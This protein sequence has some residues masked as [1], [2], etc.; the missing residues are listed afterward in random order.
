MR[1]LQL[2]FISNQTTIRWFKLINIVERNRVFTIGE[3]ADEL[4]VSQRTVANDIRHLKEHFKGSATFFSGSNGFI[5]E[6]VNFSLYKEQKKELL[7]NE[8]LF[9]LIKNIFYGRLDRVDELAHFYNYSETTF[10][11]ILAKCNPLL[12]SYGLKWVSNPL[13]IGGTE[14]CLRK[15]FKDF[16]Y[17]GI[18]TPYSV[19]PEKKLRDLVLKT[20]GEQLSFDSYEIASGT[21]PTAFYYTFYIAIRRSNQGLNVRIPQKILERVYKEKDFL[22]LFSLKE[23]IKDIFGVQLPK[24]EFAWIYLITVCNRTFNYERFEKNFYTQFNLWP[25]I[26]KITGDFLIHLK[27]KEEER[28]KLTVFLKSFFL[29]IKIKDSIEPV[30]NKA[31][32]DIL[33]VVSSHDEKHY[34]QN[35]TF[36]QRYKKQFPLSEKYI[37]DVC[38]SLT[39]YSSLLIHYYAPS[40]KIFFLL[41]GNHLAY[42]YTRIKALQLFGEKHTLIFVPIQI[43]SQEKLMNADMDLIVTNYSRYLSEFTNDTDYLLIK[44]IPDERDWLNIATK[45]NEYII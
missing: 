23:G 17:E 34:A 2:N 1:E 6:E 18:E 12:K 31:M 29:S 16:F 24:V 5:F 35:L 44:D 26:D 33:N 43:L 7:K 21:T 11:R 14:A 13:R 37:Q 3:L 39:I 20:V 30:L 25:E 10:R 42:Q 8:F 41:E 40:K 38:I 9:E 15:F 45:L 28:S 36:L 19:I 4:K 32:L 27:I 22:V